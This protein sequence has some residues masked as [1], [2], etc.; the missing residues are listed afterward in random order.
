MTPATRSKPSVRAFISYSSRDSALAASLRS[1]EEGDGISCFYAPTDIKEREIWRSRLESEIGAADVVLL[2]YTDAA[3][4]SDEV[5]QEI[6]L[7]H[8]L[9]KDVWLLKDSKIAIAPRFH[10]FELGARYQAF[11]FDAGTELAAFERVKHELDKRFGRID[12]PSLGHIDHDANPYPGKPYTSQD[13]DFFF[14]RDAECNR[15]LSDIYDGEE[16][17]FFV[18]GPS[19]A[20][21]SSLIDAGLRRLL[22]KRWWFSETISPSLERPETMA[23][24]MWRLAIRQLRPERNSPDSPES[25]LISEILSAVNDL[26][27]PGYLFWFDHVERLLT[28]E[29]ERID[30][31]FRIAHDLLQRTERVRVIISFRREML[32]QAEDQAE[33][34]LPKGS[35]RKWFL[36][37]LSREGAYVSIVDPAKKK[38][39]VTIEKSLADAMVNELARGEYEDRD[40]KK[41]ATVNPVSLQLVCRRLW[42]IGKPGLSSITRTDLRKTGRG[43]AADVKEFVETALENHLDYTIE[44]I[45]LN[46]KGGNLEQKKE[47]IRLGLLQFVTEDR[48]RQQLKEETDEKGTRVGRLQGDIVKGLYEGRL[49]QQTD[50]GLATPDYRYELVHDSLVE[51]IDHFRSKVVLL[52][53][54]NTL[55]ST[56]RGASHDK[57][58][59]NGYFNR[60]ADLVAELENARREETGFFDN[61]KEFLFRCA[62]GNQRTLTKKPISLEG[63]A[64]LLAESNIESFFSILREALS[65]K[66]GDESVRLDAIALLMQQEFRGRLT[67]EHLSE[68]GELILDAALDG[69][70]DVQQAASVAVCEIREPLGA[71]ELFDRLKD[72]ALSG[73]ARKALVWV[74]QAADRREICNLDACHAF[75]TQWRDTRFTHRIR[76]LRQLWWQRLLRSFGWMFFV[77]VMATV[78]TAFGAALAFVPMGLVGASLTL[79]DKNAGWAKGPFHGIAGGTFWGIGISASL[80]LYWVILRGGRVSPKVRNWIPAAL[81]ASLGGFIAGIALAFVIGFVFEPRS[82]YSAGWLL[83]N[84]PAGAA[85]RIADIFRYTRH[86]WWTPILGAAV[87]AGVSWSLQK[88]SADPRAEDFLKK[89][90]GAI[91]KREAMI[92]VAKMLRLVFYKSWRTFIMLALGAILVFSVLHPGPG[93]C[94]VSD[95]RWN[96]TVSPCDKANTLAP[97]PARV[98]GMVFIIWSGG[99]FLEVGILF[100]IFVARTGVRLNRDEDFLRAF[101]D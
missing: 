11:L 8:R 94:D 73:K 78:L 67:S 86:G 25:E 52:G 31:F 95:P 48:R 57:G 34:Q 5:Y 72:G 1:A 22:S 15:L 60:N 46:L 43:L 84:P 36:R 69:T 64:G 75:E 54:L 62:L 30:M 88:I 93:V 65:S 24:D 19:G 56:L 39:G 4:S 98:A 20:G 90:S 51:A 33:Q 70:S 83:T 92:A 50:I 44:K 10:A 2:L 32:S 18:Y 28:L 21:K 87:A 23:V 6:E 59:L 97:L 45:A 61:E 9:G 17:I 26:G 49:L 68:L 12:L 35:W 76:I 99:I 38:N 7:A 27:Q 77:V 40:G 89:R 74:R 81:T 91:H 37:G 80:M 29:T 63:W 66:V 101:P 3:G 96:P 55:E 82:L 79:A 14:G 71:T 100:G 13:Q 41:I 16:R 42:D 47:L 85:G 53:T 58:G